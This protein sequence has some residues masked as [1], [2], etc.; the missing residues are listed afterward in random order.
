MI[1]ALAGRRIDAPDADPPRFPGGAVEAVRGRIRRAL[2]EAGA[3][4][5]VGSGACGADLIAMDEAE[6]LGIH[7]R[8]MILPFA[9]AR[10]RE[11]SVADRP[12]PWGEMFDRVAA[13]VEAAGGLIVLGL[14]GEPGGAYLAVN[15][16]ILDEAARLAA[17][18]GEGLLAVVA[19]DGRPRGEGDVTE[20][21]KKE[22]EARGVR[23][24]EVSTLG[25]GI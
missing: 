20:A 8:L 22:A 18:R 24:V 21:F 3:T 16:A 19:W 5:L 7:L 4:G 10:F 12:G 14:G 1:V 23:V 9:R 25:E 15:L 17:D 13:E 6:R 2:A 11:T